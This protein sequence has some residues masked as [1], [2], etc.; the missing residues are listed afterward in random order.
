MTTSIDKMM[1]ALNS[2]RSGLQTMHGHRPAPKVATPKTAAPAPIK[3]KAKNKG[4][5]HE[6]LGV[7]KGEKIPKAKIKAAENSPSP[8]LRQEAQFADN[9]SGFAHPAPSAGPPTIHVHI[10]GGY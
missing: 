8:A 4:K 7:P 9:A 6:K 5:L 10:H 2:K 3:I 1:T